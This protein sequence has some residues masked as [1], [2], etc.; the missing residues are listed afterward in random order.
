[1]TTTSFRIRPMLRF[2]RRFVPGLVAFGLLAFAVT[3]IGL[4]QL[5]TSAATESRALVLV[6]DLTIS[7]DELP[8][9]VEVIWRDASVA[10][11]AAAD[12]ALSVSADALRGGAAE[13]VGV[14]GTP[15]VHVIAYGDDRSET[16][17]IANAVAAALI[18]TLNESGGFGELELLEAASVERAV[19]PSRLP[20]VPVSVF[21][22][23]IAVLA[24]L[25]ALY[26]FAAPIGSIADLALTSNAAHVEEAWVTAVPPFSGAVGALRDRLDLLGGDVRFVHGGWGP[27]LTGAVA[28]MINVDDQHLDDSD[29]EPFE[30]D[31]VEVIL[32]CEGTPARTVSR[33]EAPLRDLRL[34]V[35][36][37]IEPS[38]APR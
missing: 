5:E 14:R 22:S 9:T 28:A 25:F 13:V 24:A 2:T 33:A 26:V 3:W 35:L 30:E 37:H 34:A 12:G 31:I 15:I 1:M 6:R 8:A 19:E 16:V 38:T 32:F 10:E 11:R 18:A 36:V 21:V 17:D 27:N 4:S 29:D 7:M 20:R 23:V